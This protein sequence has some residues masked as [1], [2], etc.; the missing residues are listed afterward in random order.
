MAKDPTRLGTIEDVSGATVGVVLDED[1]VSGLSF[2]EGYGYR[3]GQVGSFV[4]VPIGYTDLFGIVSQV[5]ASAVPERFAEIEVHGHRWMTVQLLGE[6]TRGGEFRRGLSQYPTIGDAVH[7]VTEAD[8]VRLYGRPDSPQYIRLGALSS[9]ESIAALVDLNMLVTRHCAVVGST[10]SGKSTTVA[11]IL[12]TLCSARQSNSCRALVIDIH[13]EYSQALQD[14]ATVFSVSP[15][16][17]RGEKPLFIPYWALNFEELLSITFGDVPSDADRGGIIEKITE[18]KRSALAKCARDGVDENT[19]NVD[20]PVP[21]SLHQLWYEFYVLVIATHLQ[22]GNQ[23]VDTVAFETDQEGKAID[24]GDAMEVRPPRCKRVDVSAEASPKIH[25][26]SS[27]L[28]IGRPLQGLAFRLRDPRYDFLFR[29]GDWLPGTDGIPKKDL[30]EL[31]HQWVECQKPVTILDLSGVPR[32]ILHTLIGA[33]LRIVFDSLYWA[34][35]LSEGGR[36][37]PLLVILEEAHAYLGRED[38]GH[39][40]RAVRRIVREGRKYGIGAMIVSQR[41]SEIDATILSQCGTFFAMRL[42]NTQDRSHVTS[43]VSDNL[44]GLFAML[45]ILRTGEAIIVG[46]A[47]NIPIRAMI[48]APPKHRRPDSQDPKVFDDYG[49]G[50]WNRQREPVDYE[51]V[52][53][54]WRAQN[55]TST[56]RI[57]FKES[58]GS[59]MDWIQLAS[60]NLSRARYDPDT[61]TLEIEFKDGRV[62]QYFDVPPQVFEGLLDAPSHGGFLHSQIKGHYRYVRI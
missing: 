24:R 36:E 15:D 40:S 57:R 62:Y 9:S 44:E 42:S 16:D 11:G 25:L 22:T 13:G 4:R 43:V 51:E 58:G 50:G 12:N 41:P 33:L 52:V 1:T 7:L 34:R 55:P 10:G 49:P 47:V 19:V 53:E 31:V 21:F 39:A 20:S 59:D 54:L 32:E 18:M 30:D 35:N 2:V 23:S 38:K 45:P 48:E 17:K 56:R 8:L 37:R 46:E 27:R 26:S 61:S 5:G 14:R 6:G 3:I 28:S 60:S 29:P